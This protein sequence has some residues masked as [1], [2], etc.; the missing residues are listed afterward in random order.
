M[1]AYGSYVIG[2]DSESN[3][4]CTEACGNG[5]MN[6]GEDCDD[7]NTENGDNCPA[8]CKITGLEPVE[9]DKSIAVEAAPVAVGAPAVAPYPTISTIKPSKVVYGKRQL[10]I[11]V[12]GTGFNENSVII[13]NG[14][15]YG[16]SVNQAGTELKVTIPTRDLNYGPYAISVSNGGELK[17]TLKRALEV[18]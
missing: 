3:I 8:K 2:F 13:F 1:C 11:T 12:R 9:A 5:V 7:G 4:I 14:T 18:Y 17:A 16:P 15:E 10:T 6:P